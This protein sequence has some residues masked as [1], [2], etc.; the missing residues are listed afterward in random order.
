M[1]LEEFIHCVKAGHIHKTL[2]HFTDIDNLP[3]IHANG[4]LSKEQLRIGG[5]EPKRPGGNDLSHRL[6]REK[7]IFDHVSLCL[8]L[9]HPMKYVAQSDGRISHPRYLRIRPE[10]VVTEGVL[11]SFG[12]ANA[13]EVR[14]VALKE[15]LPAMDLEVLY[16]R[17]DWSDP[18]IQQRLRAAEKYEILIPRSVPVHMILDFA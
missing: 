18:E 14:I 7:G 3:S 5:I 9:N 6:D 12:V 2:Y 15:A 16:R 4:L 10:I 8:T 11:F 13:T 1:S 17:T